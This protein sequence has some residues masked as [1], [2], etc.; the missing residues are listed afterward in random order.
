MGPT[1]SAVLLIEIDMGIYLKILQNDPLFVFF[2]PFNFSV[3]VHG[4]MLYCVGLL[5][6][7]FIEV[8]LYLPNVDLCDFSGCHPGD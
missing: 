7:Y 5:P 6:M 3:V 8:A 1:S 2:F 4:V